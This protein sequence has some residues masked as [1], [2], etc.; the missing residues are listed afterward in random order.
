LKKI[1]VLP[2]KQGGILDA[3]RGQTSHDNSRAQVEPVELIMFEENL[4]FIW[5]AG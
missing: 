4:S 1:S 3:A 2:G 5:Q